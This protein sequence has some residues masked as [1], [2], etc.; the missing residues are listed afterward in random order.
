MVEIIPDIFTRIVDRSEIQGYAEAPSDAGQD[1]CETDIGNA[2]TQ[3]FVYLGTPDVLQLDDQLP[4]RIHPLVKG[5]E[6]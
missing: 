1:P 3:H 2:G 4:E 6:M 5:A